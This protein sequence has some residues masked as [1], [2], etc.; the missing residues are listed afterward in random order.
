ML[1]ALQVIEKNHPDSADECFREVLNTFLNRQDPPPR[2]SEVAEALIS[3]SVD[4]RKLL[5][6][7]ED[8]LPD[9]QL[10]KFNNSKFNK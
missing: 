3:E 5:S 4:H 6:K 9:E 8:L 2:V 7:I 10:N 1:I